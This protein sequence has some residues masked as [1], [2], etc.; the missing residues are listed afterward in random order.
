ML[1]IQRQS[2]SSVKYTTEMQMQLSHKRTPRIQS[3]NGVLQ[4]NMS[5]QFFHNMSLMVLNR[6]L[7]LMFTHDIQNTARE[8]ELYLSIFSIDY[9]RIHFQQEV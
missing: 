2:H 9:S 1:G 8:T 4:V 7:A 6:S 3:W 5:F